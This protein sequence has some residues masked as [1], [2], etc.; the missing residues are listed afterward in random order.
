MAIVA[1]GFPSISIELE[2]EDAIALGLE[3]ISASLRSFQE[4]LRESVVRVLIPSIRENFD[5]EGRPPWQ[6][7]ADAT[8]LRRGSSGPILNRT[9]TLRSEATS[10]ENW[11][12]GREEATMTGVSAEYGAYHQEGTRNMPARPFVMIQP[13]DEVQILDIF[14]DWVDRKIAEGGFR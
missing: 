2:G 11:N 6:R 8:V 3:Q 9:G 7:L 1:P 12:I 10:L 5:S 14:G 13:E 4:P